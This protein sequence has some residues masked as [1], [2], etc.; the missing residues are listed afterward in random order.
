MNGYKEMYL[1]MCSGE[2]ISFFYCLC[3]CIL[4]LKNMLERENMRV[5]VFYRNMCEQ[6]AVCG[7]L[8]CTVG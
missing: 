8:Q 3:G 5:G 2:N 6:A 7:M 1:R 4:S